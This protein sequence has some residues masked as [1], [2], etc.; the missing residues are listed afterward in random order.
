MYIVLLEA[1]H[2][3]SEE[4]GEHTE[5][6]TLASALRPQ[7]SSRSTSEDTSSVSSIKQTYLRF[8]CGCG[9][10]TVL[11]YATGKV[12]PNQRQLPFPKLGFSEVLTEDIISDIDLFE[13]TLRERSRDMHV[14][15]VSVMFKTTK[16][17]SNREIDLDEVKYYL[18]LLLE[19][20]GLFSL[21]YKT[22]EVKG[23]LYATQTFQELILYLHKH[24]CSWFNYE[25]IKY[26]RR[27]FLHKFSE[28]E[29]ID[30]YER[31]FEQYVSQR[32]FLFLDDIDPAPPN[33][34]DVVCKVDTEF[35]QMSY[36]LIGHLKF[37]FTKIIGLSKHALTFKGAREGCTE[38]IFRAPPYT[39]QL[40]SLVTYQINRLRAHEF[41]Q[42][43]IAGQCIFRDESISGEL[44]FKFYCIVATVV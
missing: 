14:K 20:K 39:Q 25:P 10:C 6:Q 2:E 16:E 8:V 19:P 27:E 43:K 28:D 30:D 33:H 26:L 31:H 7:E 44:S 22:D 11:D 38:L 37:E 29:L 41:I 4:Q 23:S 35:T 18:E 13:H 36:E 24:F 9:K 5:A 32:C 21:Q 40:E 42:V 12:C 1:A 15:F 34:V 3:F 17:L